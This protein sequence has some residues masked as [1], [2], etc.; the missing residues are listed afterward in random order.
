MPQVAGDLEGVEVE[1]EADSTSQEGA[2]E[3]EGEPMDQR[4]GWN[5][6]SAWVEEQHAVG[7]HAA[8]EAL[9]PLPR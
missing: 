9:D 4:M 5:K 1:V 6:D 3:G 7:G 8:S 2:L